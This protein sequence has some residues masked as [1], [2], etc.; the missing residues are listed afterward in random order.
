M[1]RS[2]DPQA[3]LCS[4]EGPV[5]T[6]GAVKAV[7][8]Y[9]GQLELKKTRVKE[10]EKAEECARIGRLWGIGVRFECCEGDI[11]V[12]WYACIPLGDGD[13]NEP[14]DMRALAG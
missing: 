1:R 8:A 10:R 4:G 13:R 12:Y 11:H 2:D 14:T 3:R 5:P 6:L 7:C 9:K